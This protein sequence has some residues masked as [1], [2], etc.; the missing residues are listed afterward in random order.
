MGKIPWGRKGGDQECF[1]CLKDYE[2]SCSG[3]SYFAVATLCLDFCSR[4]KFLLF[5][6]SITAP[7]FGS[8]RS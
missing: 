7:P 1:L 3:L 4:L 6:V 2:N 8:I 5:F